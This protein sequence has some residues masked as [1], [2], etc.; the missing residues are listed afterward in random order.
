[1]ILERSTS[2]HSYPKIYALGHSAI[3]ELLFDEVTVEEKIDGSQISFGRFDGE[4][5]ARSKG[6]TLNIE[7]P[8]QMFFE[9]IRVINSLDLQDGW[10]YRAEYLKKPKHNVLAYDRIPAQHLIIFDINT[11]EEEYLPY[12]KKL[13]EA[14]RLGLEIVPLMFCG[15]IEDPASVV[16][17]LQNTSVLGGQKIEGIVVKNY[18]RF[19]LDK[20]VLMGKYVSEAFKEVHSAEWKEAN[21][22]KTDIVAHL[23]A[24]YKTPARWNKAIQH[25]KERGE[26]TNSPK[27]IGRLIKEVQTDIEAEEKEEIKNKLYANVINHVRRGVV[28]G[29]PEYYKEYLMKEQFLQG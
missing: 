10:T 13:A 1:M 18:S 22:T 24:S 16:A 5:R 19:G 9:A 3:K 12:A 4:L 27:D 29:L 14:N 26:L 17:L 2:Y 25:L 11:A 8:E 23:I 28:G 15:R 6:A 7:Y 20:K 21:P